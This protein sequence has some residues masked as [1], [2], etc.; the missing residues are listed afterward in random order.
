MKKLIRGD[1]LLV[2]VGVLGL[3]MVGSVLASDLVFQSR[4]DWVY[5]ARVDAVPPEK[6]LAVMIERDNVYLVRNEV[7]IM[8]FRAKNAYGCQV[9]WDE[10]SDRFLDPCS[11]SAYTRDG[12][13]VLG[14][15][16]CNLSHYPHK[17]VNNEILIDPTHLIAGERHN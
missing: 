3:L 14:P 17:I 1:V 5:V 8:A 11:G 15:D 13:N 12:K 16:C 7:E 2:L 9:V 4:R 10:N 6:P